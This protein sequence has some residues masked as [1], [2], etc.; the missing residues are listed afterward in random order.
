MK[1]AEAIARILQAEG[2]ELLT[3]FPDNEIIDAAATLG[4]RPIM[5]R[6]ERVAIN[7][8]DGYS[9]ATN[10]RRIGVCAVQYGPGAENAFGAIAQAYSDNS[11]IL[12][13]PGGFERE[14][15]GVDPNFHATINYQHIT[16]WAETVPAASRIPQLMRRAFTLLRSG[17][18]GP[19]MLEVPGDVMEEEVPEDATPYVPT[20]RSRPLGNPDD[21]RDVVDALISAKAPVIVAG[22]GIFYA[23]A[24]EELEELAELVQAPVMTTMNGKSVFPENHPL[25]LGAGGRSQPTT[26]DVFLKKADLVLGIGTSFTRSHYITTIPPA[27][28]MA[29]ITIDES[30]VN[31]DYSI[32]YGVIGDAKAVLGQ[33]LEDLRERLGR[34]GRRGDE[35][36][37]RQVESEKGKFMA[38]W[39]PRLTTDDRPISAY[40][41]IWELMHTV[42]RRRTTV[43]HDA[44]SPRDQMLPFYE[45]IV[46]HGYIGWGKSTQLGT[47]LG[48]AMGAKLANPDWLSVNVM[49][50][51]SFGMVG[52]DFETAV[53]S[54]I[55]I[56]TVVLNNGLMAGYEKYMPVAIER[57]ELHRL[58]GNYADIARDMGGY[59]ERIEHPDEIRPALDRA[60]GQVRDGRAALVEVM[61]REEAVYPL[62]EEIA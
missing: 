23:E 20:S 56:L 26:I 19:V 44:G 47:G 62:R 16:K 10:G 40:R 52:M 30:D 43:T 13:L 29:Q 48:L 42:D 5:A 53:R 54:Q 28:T 3:C 31:K 55:P 51:A 21:A 61:T 49:G 4:L 33:M 32:S 9:R 36:V 37:A 57:Y 11:P 38:G 8:A 24:W 1:G 50:D 2:V 60:I 6:T 17:K 35:T 22:Q 39:L 25:A 27:K 45:S 46:P 7:I 34:N 14:E 41:V 15:L 18:P 59:G 58:T 12:F